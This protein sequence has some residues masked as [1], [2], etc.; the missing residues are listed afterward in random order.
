MKFAGIQISSKITEIVPITREAFTLVIHLTNVA[1]TSLFDQMLPTPA[2]VA[3]HRVGESQPTFRPPSQNVIADYNRRYFAFLVVQSFDFVEVMRGDLIEPVR[4]DWEHVDLNDITTYDRYL[5]DFK[6]AG[7]TESEV[8]KIVQ[9]AL[10]VNTLTDEMLQAARDNFL[11]TKRR[12]ALLA[13]SQ[14]DEPV[15]TESGELA[16]DSASNPPES[17]TAGTT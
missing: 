17:E 9:V 16:N 10:R 7:F 5:D 15:T 1:D 3:V 8:S 6:A 11:A 14:K 13:N 12:V 4:F 2:P